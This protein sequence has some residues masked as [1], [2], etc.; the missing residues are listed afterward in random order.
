VNELISETTDKNALIHAGPYLDRRA[1]NA[2]L[3]RIDEPLFANASEQTCDAICIVRLPNRHQPSVSACA[4]FDSDVA[5]NA[6]LEIG[7]QSD[8]ERRDA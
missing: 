6:D 8:R 7:T 4:G 2:G 1:P 3:L 5:I